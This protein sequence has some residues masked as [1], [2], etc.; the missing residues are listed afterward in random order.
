MSVPILTNFEDVLN[1]YNEI[2]NFVKNY[3]DVDVVYQLKSL[4]ATNDKILSPHCYIAGSKAVT[5]LRQELTMAQEKLRE[6]YKSC[7]E[8]D[9][10]Y[11]SYIYLIRNPK[12]PI[13]ARL[14]IT[15]LL[16]QHKEQYYQ[17]YH[18]KLFG[19]FEPNDIDLFVL[20]SVSNHRQNIGQLDVVYKSYKT[21]EELIINFDLP[22]CR[23]ARDLNDKFYVSLHCLASLINGDIFLPTCYINEEEYEQI[24]K[25]VGIKSRWNKFQFRIAKYEHRGYNF[26]FYKT[27]F[28]QSALLNG[29]SY[30]KKSD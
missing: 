15:E 28:V 25:A 30:P 18:Q 23:A 12:L 4:E 22:C 19:E 24:I 5:L 6:N 16:T 3:P 14:T 20:N 13:N 26:H 1:K 11:K 29:F 9:D 2:V 10:I 21:P 17:F 8:N 27:S 7:Y